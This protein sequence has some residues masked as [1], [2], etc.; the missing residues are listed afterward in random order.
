MVDVKLSTILLLIIIILPIPLVGS[1]PPEGTS[2]TLKLIDSRD[3]N[4]ITGALVKVVVDGR[5]AISARTDY[6]GTA[7]FLMN[8]PA[9][10]NHSVVVYAPI[11]SDGGEEKVY[12][13]IRHILYVR[14]GDDVHVEYEMI[15]GSMIKID[16]Y[17]LLLDQG[18]PIGR[19]SIE[20]KVVGRELPSY[21]VTEFGYVPGMDPLVFGI[22]RRTVVV[23]ADEKVVLLV[24]ASGRDLLY[25]SS[26]GNPIQLPWNKETRLDLS[27]Y[28]LKADWLKVYSLHKIVEVLL[29]LSKLEGFYLGLYSRIHDEGWRQL[30]KTDL[31]IEDGRNYLEAFYYL[32]ETHS[33]LSYIKG[34]ILSLVCSA[35]VTLTSM[36]IIMILSALSISAILYDGKNRRMYTTLLIFAV[37][38]VGVYAMF[39]FI[40]KLDIFEVMGIIYTPITFMIILLILP[41]YLPDIRTRGDVSLIAAI[42][43]SIEISLRNMRRRKLRTALTLV[44]FSVLVTA[45]LMLLSSSFVVESFTAIRAPQLLVSP[46]TV[47]IT[48]VQSL[49]DAGIE[50]LSFDDIGWIR[51]LGV[52][53]SINIRYINSPVKDPLMLRTSEGR[54]SHVYG[55]LSFSRIEYVDDVVKA[56]V[57]GDLPTNGLSIAVSRRVAKEL[58]AKVG[59]KVYL[60]RLS[61]R[62]VGVFDGKK[63]GSAL[64]V[65]GRPLTPLY[66]A[67]LQIGNSATLVLAP[68][69]GDLTVIVSEEA[70]HRLGLKPIGI[71][72][73]ATDL[74]GAADT[75]RMLAKSF[76]YR[77]TLALNEEQIMTFTQGTVLVF[78]G[79]SL[80]VPLVIVFSNL[81]IVMYESIN[82]RKKEIYAYSTI[83]L[84]PSHIMFMVIT[85]ALSMGL[86]SG[87]IGY[88]A[89][90]LLFSLFNAFG[91]EVPLN[92][93]VTMYNNLSVFLLTALV[94]VT[95]AIIPSAKASKIATSTLQ[96]RWRL[97]SRKL[98]SSGEFVETLPLRISIKRLGEFFSY[99][100][101]RFREESSGS[102]S[103]HITDKSLSLERPY[104]K[105]LYS[106]G[107]EV[108]MNPCV[109]ENLILFERDETGNYKVIVKSAPITVLKGFASRYAY[110]TIGEI[111]RMVLEWSAYATRVAVTFS[112]NLTPIYTIIKKL[113]PYEV[114]IVAEPR[115][116]GLLKRLKTRLY[117]EGENVSALRVE[118]V[119][120]HKNSLEELRGKISEMI[121]SSPIV[122]INSDNP[123]LS[124][125]ASQLAARAGKKIIAVIDERSINEIARNPFHVGRIVELS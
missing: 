8:L 66:L 46:G 56:F 61:L 40:R 57:E 44:T 93:S 33:S 125:L 85:E 98:T 108:G 5:R 113:K 36:L 115:Q 82:E 109:T 124:Y 117:L 58:N 47:T 123:L 88:F 45:V 114:I 64:D 32:K 74:H 77:I 72:G 16:G 4:P 60:N 43:S 28:S 106:R 2:L 92:A 86:V 30:K 69:E 111:R 14:S 11:F 3:G 6:S 21:A 13:P 55:I 12:V 50:F 99:L 73:V 63:L 7:R 107:K 38:V 31:L 49:E 97:T 89:S 103:I 52:L 118:Q 48:R 76:G 26:D 15:R 121:S 94:S 67:P 35:S 71:T 70:A 104:I 23:P 53:D 54:G 100:Q 18:A 83:G 22:D 105:F 112:W 37:E 87:G 116:S 62:L 90:A 96:R 1:Q 27:K 110:E 122:C 9:G 84:N 42:R 80:V 119:D 120:L 65:E 59:D 79:S 34:E 81:F 78:T 75:M 20:V 101:K 68:V 41:E 24:K 29:R 19:F 25:V 91:I 17:L 39:P 10:L 95:A 51:S 102:V